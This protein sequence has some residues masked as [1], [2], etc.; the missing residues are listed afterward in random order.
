MNDNRYKECLNKIDKYY[1]SNPDITTNELE[2]TIYNIEYNVLTKN[3]SIGP[4][5]IL[6]VDIIWIYRVAFV[7]IVLAI[8]LVDILNNS[9]DGTYYFGAIFYLAGL[10][11]GLNI[12]GVG[13][14]FLLSHGGI[15]IGIML[16]P[17]IIN[18][19]KSPLM[20]D[21]ANNNIM[22]ILVIAFIAIVLAILM[23]VFYNLSDQFKNKNYSL[24]VILLLYMI[25][26]V[27]IKIIPII[28]N[29]HIDNVF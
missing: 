19:L 6:D 22:S 5:K 16:V 4:K 25:G 14:I 20:S 3:S 7:I 27:I 2:K 13:L 11:I 23:T 18:I 21:L 10:F 29:I 8:G 9:F 15:G 1:K 24:P 12:K 17:T 28:Y 26:I